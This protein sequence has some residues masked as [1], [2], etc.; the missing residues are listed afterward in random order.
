MFRARTAGAAPA[1]GQP[2]GVSRR[3]RS[4]GGTAASGLSNGG[5]VRVRV[6]EL[7][8][9]VVLVIIVAGILLVVLK[10]NPGNSIVSQIHDWARTL[11]GPFDGIFSFKT[12]PTAI[13]VN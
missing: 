12:P 9:S 3:Q 6:I 2:V 1:L 5:G 10:A 8:V 13:A 11:A 4:G 7:V